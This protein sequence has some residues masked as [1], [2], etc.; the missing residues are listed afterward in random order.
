MDSEN[1]DVDVDGAK[2]EIDTPVGVATLIT[3]E[4]TDIDL[5]AGD[6][7]EK[8]QDGRWII[9]MDKV[10]DALEQWHRESDQTRP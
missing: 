2:M 1:Y 5:A 6:W 10:V 8:D 3:C 7:S 9:L 4:H